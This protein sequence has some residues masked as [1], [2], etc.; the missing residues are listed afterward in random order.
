MAS[1][2]LCL[3]LPLESEKLLCK[4]HLSNKAAH[5][6]ARPAIFANKVCFAVY[7]RLSFLITTGIRLSLMMQE[8]LLLVL[9][10][11]LCILRMIN[12]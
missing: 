12:H 8:L 5:N 9:L 6:A 3:Y 4:H 7:I 1:Y 10:T 11:E 2:T